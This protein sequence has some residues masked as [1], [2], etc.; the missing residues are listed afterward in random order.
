M[1]RRGHG[2]AVIEVEREAFVRLRTESSQ[3]AEANRRVLCAVS[4][5]LRD[6]QQE[7]Q[8]QNY[9]NVRDMVAA[10]RD[11]TS[12][13]FGHPPLLAAKLEEVAPA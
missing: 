12:D 10:L 4:A 8:Q 11:D 9:G 1:A 5:T 3:R 2:A 6:I 13:D 7:L